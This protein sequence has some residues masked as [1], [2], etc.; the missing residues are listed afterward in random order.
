MPKD[1]KQSTVVRWE[2]QEYITHDIDFHCCDCS[3]IHLFDSL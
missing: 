3:R 1:K 2:A